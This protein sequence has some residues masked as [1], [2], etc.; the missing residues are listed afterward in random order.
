MYN[1]HIGET[2][3][4]PQG[5]TRWEKPRDGAQRRKRK[6][7]MDGQCRSCC[8]LALFIFCTAA[9]MVNS[10]PER[11]EFAAGKLCE[12]TVTAP[13]DIIDEA[14]T[15]R[16]QQEAMQKVQPVYARNE[17]IWGE[18]ESGLETAFSQLEAV[19]TASE[20][21]LYTIRLSDK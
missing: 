21:H 5:R 8:I 20:K 18:V 6:N 19:R 11:H 12:E 16:L 2:A 1:A 3:G 4:R 9:A 14:A 7:G 17:D 15:Q 13:R 10:V